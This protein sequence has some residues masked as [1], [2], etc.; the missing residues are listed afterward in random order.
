MFRVARFLFLFPLA[1]VVWGAGG[2]VFSAEDGGFS[3]I[4]LSGKW[5]FALDP[6]DAGVGGRWFAADIKGDSIALPSTTEIERKGEPSKQTLH[7]KL[8]RRHKY[9]GKAWYQRDITIPES[10]RGRRVVLTLE[11]SKATTVWLDGNEVGAQIRRLS[12]PHRHVLSLDA[13][14]GKHRLTLLVDNNPRLFPAGGHMIDEDIQGNWNGVLGEISLSQTGAVWIERVLV[15]PDAALKTA[16]VEV[17]LAKAPSAPAASGRVRV[18]DG[19]NPARVL[20][21]APFSLSAPTGVFTATVALPEKTGAW[22][23][24]TPATSRLRVGVG[25]ENAPA[26]DDARVVAVP[27]RRLSGDGTRL[28]C[29]GAP[30][31]LRGKHDA[32]AFPLT[33]APPMDAASWRRFF[34]RCKE[35]GINHVRYHSCCPPE[36]AFAAADE[37][38][39]YIQAENPARGRFLRGT[40]RLEY[41]LDEARAILDEYGNHPSFAFFALGN[42]L[43]DDRRQLAKIVS[44]LRERDG[45]RRFFSSGANNGFNQAKQPEADDFWVTFRTTPGARGNIRASYSHADL[46]LGHI[47]SAPPDTLHDYSKALKYA[48]I[49]VVSHEVGQY[50]VSPNYDEI[51]RFS[52]V[53]AARNLE[54]FRA[55]LERAGMLGQWRDFFNASLNLALLCYKEDVEAALRT[56]NFAGFQLLDL[57]DFHAQG[58]ALVGVLDAFMEPKSPDVKKYWTQFC[59]PTVPLAL[60]EQYVW[61]EGDVLTADIKIAHHGARD[62]TGVVG[63][64]LRGKGFHASR[65]ETVEIKRGGL[66]QAFTFFGPDGDGCL[67]T[68]EN[69]PEQMRLVVTVHDETGLEKLAENSWD[70]WVY[71]NHLDSELA[72]EFEGVR[73]THDARAA[74]KALDAGGRVLLLNPP[75]RA[76][77]APADSGAPAL[78]DAEAA[79]VVGGVADRHA[80]REARSGAKRV[81]GL[82]MPDFWNYPMFLSIAGKLR[83]EPSPGT[84]GLLCDPAHP[85]FAAFPTQAH[86]NWQWWRLVK[87]SESFVLDKTPADFRPI[88]Q[89]IDNFARNHKLGLVFEARAAAGGGK[90]LVCGVAE[91][92][93]RGH[94]EGRQLLFAMARYMKSPAFAP[95]HVLP[96]GILSAAEKKP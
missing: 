23:E 78:T 81:K 62:F 31:F 36:A 14:P 39:I 27:N 1:L 56:A 91:D 60:F 38:G 73:V 33:G 85:L 22:S 19:A 64:M 47:E 83:R 26:E 75:A 77:A 41:Q 52:G 96:E 46:P 8:T 84:L 51:P 88:V 65:E 80:P 59:A 90:L 70:I 24:W 61:T 67:V 13:K 87:N 48:T 89:V 74:Q 35:Y 17:S 21:E 44:G 82:F 94:P 3:P 12:T 37:A 34:A 29:N 30:V 55:R 16:S 49:P 69:E 57:Q 10:W 28:L 32:L 76:P 9:V 86:S 45:F 20:G 18:T 50:Q 54:E 40:G 25:A 72:K 4:D 95:A 43:S 11:R 63:V 58:T 66:T 68:D 93:L 53:L 92:T 5:R 2:T 15:K 42:E 7:F 79:Q 6:Q 71:P